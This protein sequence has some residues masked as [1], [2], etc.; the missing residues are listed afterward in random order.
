V[1]IDGKSFVKGLREVLEQIGFAKDE[2]PKYSF[3]AWRHFYTTYMIKKLDRKLLKGQTGHLTDEMLAH[4]S[5][6]ETEGDRE[7]IRATQREIFAGLIPER[8]KKLVFKKEP[9]MILACG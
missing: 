4:Y 3:H 9:E 5:D 7:I 2:T 1:P 6:H 8:P